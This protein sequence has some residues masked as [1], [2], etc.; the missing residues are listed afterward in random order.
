MDFRRGQIDKKAIQSSCEIMDFDRKSFSTSE[1]HANK[2][3]VL[4]MIIKVNEYGI[5]H[6]PNSYE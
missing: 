4:W 5:R 6:R 1:S 2:K 3:P